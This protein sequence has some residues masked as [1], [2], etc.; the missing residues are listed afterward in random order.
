MTTNIV[1]IPI[2]IK[3]GDNFPEIELHQDV[4]PDLMYLSESRITQRVPLLEFT[5]TKLQKIVCFYL[6]RQK[7]SDTTFHSLSLKQLLN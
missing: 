4:N 3:K 5:T 6:S 7:V 1:S 2:K